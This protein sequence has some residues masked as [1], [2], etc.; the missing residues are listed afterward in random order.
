MNLSGSIAVLEEVSGGDLRIDGELM[1]E[2]PADE[3]RL[4]MVAPRHAFDPHLTDCNEMAFALKLTRVSKEDHKEKILKAR[5]LQ[6]EALLDRKPH[7]LSGG[8][9]QWVAIARALTGR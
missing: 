8:L 1:N 3:L 9:C 6:L 2:V 7:Q 5:I 4:A